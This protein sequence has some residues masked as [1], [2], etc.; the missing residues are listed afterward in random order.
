MLKYVVKQKLG[1]FTEFKIF[2]AKHNMHLMK[3]DIY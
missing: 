3:Y 1:K 2:D